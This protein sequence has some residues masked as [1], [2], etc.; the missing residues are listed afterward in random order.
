MISFFHPLSF[1][2]VVLGEN[3]ASIIF[4]PDS[5]VSDEKSLFLKSHLR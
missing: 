3:L 1:N 5:N 2:G 4:F